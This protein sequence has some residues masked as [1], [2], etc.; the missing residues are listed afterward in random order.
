MFN[1]SIVVNIW[2]IAGGIVLATLLLNLFN[3]FVMWFG[4]HHDFVGMLFV[5]TASGAIAWV[6]AA[7]L[8]WF[9][10]LAV[11]ATKQGLGL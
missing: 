6:L 4:E 2:T 9:V 10:W 5:W 7:A 1:S 8:A 3:L 11:V